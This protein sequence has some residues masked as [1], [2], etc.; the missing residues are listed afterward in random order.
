MKSPEITVN[1]WLDE[2]V[3]LGKRNDEGSTAKEL[4][5]SAGCSVKIM[6]VRLGQAKSLGRL[7][8][9]FRTTSRLDGRSLQ[10]PV[11][12]VLPPAKRGK[13]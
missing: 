6:L 7:E 8:V 12:R 11:Y 5:D 3:A 4:A 9:G 2:L 1:E 10:V 13:K